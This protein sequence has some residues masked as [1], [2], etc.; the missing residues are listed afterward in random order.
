MKAQRGVAL[1]IALG[2]LLILMLLLSQGIGGAAGEARL[3]SLQQ[4]RHAAFEAAEAGLVA[5]RLQLATLGSPVAPPPQQQ[6]V[7][8]S[9]LPRSLTRFVYRGESAPPAGYSLGRFS[10]RDWELH[11]RGE[12]ARGAVVELTE[13][14]Q[15]LEPQ[16]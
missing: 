10:A 12:A 6:R 3:A 15:Q 1:P 13:G 2:L 9:P 11:S 4:F 8:A 5:G 14:L 7:D 16:P